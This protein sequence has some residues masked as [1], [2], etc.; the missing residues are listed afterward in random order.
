MSDSVIRVLRWVLLAF[1]ILSAL[2]ATFLYEGFRRLVLERWFA[3]NERLGAA[4][5]A[6]MR[7]PTLHRTWLLLMAAVFAVLWWYLGTTSGDAWLRGT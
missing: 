1:A 2:Q 4:V 3:A 5:P 7:N 6:A